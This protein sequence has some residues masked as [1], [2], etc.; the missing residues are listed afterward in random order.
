MIPETDERQLSHLRTFWKS[1]LGEQQFSKM[2]AQF[3]EDVYTLDNEGR[4][5]LHMALIG[6]ESRTDDETNESVRGA[7]RDIAMR[8]DMNIR[9]SEYFQKQ[10]S[11]PLPARH[12]VVHSAMERTRTGDLDLSA[13]FS[14]G[15]PFA[16]RGYSDFL[17]QQRHF[18]DS[19]DRS[20]H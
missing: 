19:L 17:K 8:L 6:T 10:G 14:T 11:G 3:R 9:V 13:S 5:K 1:D 12:H 15:S 2:V 16:S 18:R 20:T 7:A 4:A